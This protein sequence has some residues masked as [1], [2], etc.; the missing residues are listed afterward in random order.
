MQCLLIYD[1]PNDRARQKIADACLDYG[2]TRLQYSAF[3]GNLSRAHQRAL[4]T[5]IEYRLGTNTGNI[6]L[7]PLDEASWRGRRSLVQQR[8]D[9]GDDH[10]D[11]HDDAEGTNGT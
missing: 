2:L 1:I 4:F 5:E 10:D 11:D 6:Q 7:F 3:L 8:D 9:Q